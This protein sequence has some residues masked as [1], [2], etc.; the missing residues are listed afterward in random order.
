MQLHSKFQRGWEPFLIPQD[1]E[2]LWPHITIQ[3]QAS[4]EAATELLQF[5]KDNFSA[6]EAISTGLQ[7]W[8]NNGGNWKLFR[9]FP[10]VKD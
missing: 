1:R 10:F 8:E 7:L 4:Q 2:E 6:F 3:S 5:L 9:E